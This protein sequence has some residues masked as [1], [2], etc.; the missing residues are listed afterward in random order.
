MTDRKIVAFKHEQRPFHTD[1]NQSSPIFLPHAAANFL[2]MSLALVM[3]STCVLDCPAAFWVATQ[4]LTSSALPP[5]R[6]FSLT[7]ASESIFLYG[8]TGGREISSP[9]SMLYPFP[10][11]HVLN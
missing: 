1:I 4:F 11:A 9:S 5:A 2:C 6:L 7:V 10:L 8:G 3:T